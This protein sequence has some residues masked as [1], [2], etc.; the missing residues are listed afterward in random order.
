MVGA[1]LALGGAAHGAETFRNLQKYGDC[2]VNRGVV[3]A[4]KL[5]VPA[6]RA[7]V[8]AA[9]QCKF[10]GDWRDDEGGFDDG[11]IHAIEQQLAQGAAQPPNN[12]TDAQRRKIVLPAI[13][14]STDC[15]A[16]EAAKDPDILEL[17]RDG[18]LYRRTPIYA[19]R[20]GPQLDAMTEIYD[21]VYG[22][23]KGKE[24]VE[25]PYGADLPRAVTERIQSGRFKPAQRSPEPTPPIPPISAPKFDLEPIKPTLSKLDECLTYEYLSGNYNF[26]NL[27][28]TV[29]RT[30][31]TCKLQSAKFALECE[32]L[33]QDKVNNV[34]AMCIYAYISIVK[35]R[36]KK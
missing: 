20:C 15:I 21:R 30:M 4:R 5:G 7:S 9:T 26:L 11:V 2:L 14:L 24:F 29:S 25:G 31:D 8:L 36:M 16:A 6:E 32:Q 18:I 33:F 10:V 27:D 3:I 19:D 22:A 23:G 17:I 35:E 28:Q 12:L 13:K 1:I 34:R